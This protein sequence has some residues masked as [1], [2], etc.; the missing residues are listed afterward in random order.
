MNRIFRT[1]ILLAA[2][3]AVGNLALA[4][5]YSDTTALFRKAAESSKYF[6]HSY[7][8]AVFPSVGKGGIGVGGAF[9][10]GQVFQGGKVAADV[11]LSQLS[12]GLQFG[13]QAYS[14]IIFFENKTTF[15]DFLSGNF[16]FGADASAV[17]LTA[18]ASAS[19]S[20]AG[21]ASAGAS[22]TKDNAVTA[23]AY[24]HGV[25]VFT[26]AKGGLMYQAA[27]SGQKFSI[28]KK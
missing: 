25:A 7:G 20:S 12:I 3:L 6:G 10:R 23:G 27:I 21:G 9:G 11:S 2:S 16:E 24:H 8:Y 4:D 19:A 5:D 22:G 15:D 1:L 14:E 18:S 17:A 26:I 13:G 28:T